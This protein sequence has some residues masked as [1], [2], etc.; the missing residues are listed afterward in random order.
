MTWLIN[1]TWLGEVVNIDFVQ[2]TV[3]RS[4]RGIDLDTTILEGLIN[5]IALL[6][7]SGEA[8]FKCENLFGN[9]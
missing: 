1:I 2:V 5:S 6:F 7:D 4:D 8:T 3:W 9:L